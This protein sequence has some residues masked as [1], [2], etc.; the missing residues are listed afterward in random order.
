MIV[1]VIPSLRYSYPARFPHFRRGTRQ[2]N[3]RTREIETVSTPVPQT[4]SLLN[5]LSSLASSGLRARSRRRDA[6]ASLLFQAT[7]MMASNSEVTCGFTSEGGW[8]FARQ[9]RQARLR[10]CVSEGAAGCQFVEHGAPAKYVRAG[11]PLFTSL[12][13]ETY[14]SPCQSPPQSWSGVQG[15]SQR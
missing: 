6:S 5:R 13:R 3:P 12:A 10:L 1:S 4:A 2:W 7:R 9:A 15:Q 11:V 8:G 14:R